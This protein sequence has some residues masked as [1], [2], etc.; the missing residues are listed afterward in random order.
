M[1]NLSTLVGQIRNRMQQKKRSCRQLTMDHDALAK[2]IKR[3]G[4]KSELEVARKLRNQLF[5][6]SRREGCTDV[7]AKPNYRQVKYGNQHVRSQRSMV[8]LNGLEDG[9]A[10]AEQMASEG[11]C[12]SAFNTLVDTATEIPLGT[13]TSSLRTRAKKAKHHVLKMCQAIPRR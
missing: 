10:A 2:A 13:R 9:F 3:G 1:S 4:A 11:A 8:K 6:A 7:S 5:S 12:A